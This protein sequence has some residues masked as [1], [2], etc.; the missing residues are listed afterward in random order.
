[1]FLLQ[2][3]IFGDRWNTIAESENRQEIEQKRHQI[4]VMPMT[5]TRIARK[6]LNCDEEVEVGLLAEFDNPNVCPNCL[7]PWKE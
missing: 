3:S 6:C 5:L 1:M 4:K 7:T 2:T